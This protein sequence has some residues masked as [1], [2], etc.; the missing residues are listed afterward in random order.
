MLGGEITSARCASE[1]TPMTAIHPGM[2]DQTNTNVARDGAAKKVQTKFAVKDGMKDMTEGSKLSASPAH[3]E[4]GPDA[5]SPDV[6]DPS[7][8]IKK[9]A[10]CKA[11]WGMMDA[12][13]QSVNGDLGRAVLSEAANLGR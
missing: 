9:F 1:G 3:P 12:N 11:S 6:L 5:S 4:W 2:V 8:G 10:D 13:K 7:K